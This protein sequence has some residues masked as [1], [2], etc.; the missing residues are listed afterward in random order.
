MH[1]HYLYLKIQKNS[2]EQVLN[3]TITKLKIL[4]K[5]KKIIMIM[6]ILKLIKINWQI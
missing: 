6:K 4:I 1:N 2:K 3:L 5:K